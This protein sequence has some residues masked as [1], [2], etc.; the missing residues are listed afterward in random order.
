MPD[1]YLVYVYDMIQPVPKADPDALTRVR[2]LIPPIFINRRGWTKGYLQT[3]AHAELREADLLSH[4]CFR[5][6]TGRH[7]DE[8]GRL[9]EE[10]L[11]PCG[12]WDLS[13][14]LRLDDLVSDALGIARAPGG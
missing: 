3:I 5:D 8:K 9:L 6:F 7:L 11:E 12:T 4:H 10:R 14:Y 13:S 1:S 2:L